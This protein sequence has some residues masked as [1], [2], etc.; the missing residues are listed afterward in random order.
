M[1]DASLTIAEA[2][3]WLRCSETDVRE[4]LRTGRLCPNPHDPRDGRVSL[5][6]VVV[7][8]ESLPAEHRIFEVREPA[9][10]IEPS[11]SGPRTAFPARSGHGQ[12]HRPGLIV[13]RRPTRSFTR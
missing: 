10:R 12:D 7:L 1:R 6:A 13:E 9:A 11:S 5:N 3:A 2:A 8:A 4:H